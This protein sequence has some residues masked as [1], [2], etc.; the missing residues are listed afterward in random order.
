M[1][2]CVCV[3]VQMSTSPSKVETRE[4]C[5]TAELAILLKLSLSLFLSL[6]RHPWKRSIL[7]GGCDGGGGEG[8]EEW[9]VALEIKAFCFDWGG[10]GRAEKLENQSESHFP[11]PS[12]ALQFCLCPSAALCLLVS[13][14]VLTAKMPSSTLRISSSDLLF[15]IYS[16]PMCIN[17]YHRLILIFIIV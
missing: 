5:E 8:A 11:L 6:W 10:G 7:P 4:L 17:G 13:L 16:F 2:V 14:V 12:I 3:R 9:W 1:C 15:A